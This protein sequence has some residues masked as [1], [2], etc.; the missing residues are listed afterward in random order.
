MTKNNRYW[1]NELEKIK[2]RGLKKIIY[3][4]IEEKNKRLEQAFKIVYKVKVQ[5]I[6]NKKVEKNSKIYTKKWALF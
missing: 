4:S 6:I 2:K 5:E 1:I 3:I